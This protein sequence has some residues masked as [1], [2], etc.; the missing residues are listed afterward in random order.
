MGLAEIAEQVLREAGGGPLHYREIT[1]RASS[2]GLMTPTGETPWASI[3]AA[4]G[5][6]NRR[7]E[8]RGELPRFVGAGSGYYRLRTAATEVEQAIERWNDGTKQ[9]LLVQLGEIDPG[10]FEELIGELLERIG[11][12]DVEVTK[13]SGDGGIDVRG[14]LT[15]GGVTRVKTAIQVKRWANN[16]P[17]RIVRELRGSIGP[18]EQGLIITT[19]RF[20]KAA[21][22]EAEMTDRAPVTLINGELLVEL[23]AEFEIGVKRQS[24]PVLQLDEKALAGGT[25]A[26]DGDGAVVGTP[27]KTPPGM[28][29]SLW[30]LPGGNQAYVTALEKLLPLA[31]DQP[32]TTEFISRLQREFPQVESIATAN[33]YIR[34]LVAL[35]FVEL[36]S[37]Q[38]SLTPAGREFV[39]TQD[40]ELVREALRA[41]VVGVQ[42]LLDELARGARTMEQLQQVLGEVGLAWETNAQLGWRLHWLESVELVAADNGKYQLAQPVLPSE[43]FSTP[44]PQQ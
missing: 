7:R 34:V 19:S 35:G 5:V 4:M 6:D 17:D 11:F 18:A 40:V 23:L 13:R 25:G 33:G 16:V 26:D 37:G 42:E 14:V 43:D 20:T 1:E 41:R 12:E 22:K 36:T 29:R 44:A 9:E 30:P 21:V 39:E 24:R 3:N 32:T 8:A 28:Y 10:T 2:A 27:G 38:I 31:A 15:V